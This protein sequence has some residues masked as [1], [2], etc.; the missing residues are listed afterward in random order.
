MENIVVQAGL[1]VGAAAALL[2]YFKRRRN[3]KTVQ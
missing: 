3:R 1:W 2:L